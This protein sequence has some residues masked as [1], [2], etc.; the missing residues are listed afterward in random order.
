MLIDL[1]N[2]GI[3]TAGTGVGVLSFGPLA[4][5]LMG[6]LGWKKGINII[7][8]IMMT[9]VLFGA[10]MKPVKPRKVLIKRDSELQ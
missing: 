3:V 7:A 9:G 1:L 5:F 8:G 6:R 10:I 2:L 4:N